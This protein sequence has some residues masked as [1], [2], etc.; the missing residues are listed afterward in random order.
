MAA[1]LRALR[2][3]NVEHSRQRNDWNDRYVS[4]GSAREPMLTAP[5]VALADIESRGS[6]A[7]S[8]S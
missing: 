8:G 7:P 5:F 1:P 3:L 4:A 6:D 2:P